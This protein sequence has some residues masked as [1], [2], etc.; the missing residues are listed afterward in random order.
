MDG[1]CF[2]PSCNGTTLVTVFVFGVVVFL[3]SPWGG[4][5][6]DGL[7]LACF[8]LARNYTTGGGGIIYKAAAY[9]YNSTARAQGKG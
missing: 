9:N 3:G 6:A 5:W 1:G 4:G 7:L 2:F 8:W